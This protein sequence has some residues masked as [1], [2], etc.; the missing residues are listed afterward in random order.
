MMKFKLLIMFL[1][2]I[3]LVNANAFEQD[4][5]N[6]TLGHSLENM[7]YLENLSNQSVKFHQYCW[8]DPKSI[9]GCFLVSSI[10]L[11][12]YNEKNNNIAYLQKIEPQSEDSSLVYQL[13]IQNLK[14]NKIVLNRK[15][16]YNVDS[17][18]YADEEF[19]NINLFFKLKETDINNILKNYNLK[20]SNF[21]FRYL[22]YSENKFL[23][24]L[25]FSTVKVLSSFGYDKPQKV[26]SLNNL[27]IKKKDKLFF[28]QN[29]TYG[30]FC[31]ECTSPFF[32]LDPLT[33]IEI[34]STGQK[35]LIVGLLAYSF[36]SP[37]TLFFQMIG[38]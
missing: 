14:N 17:E 34:G 38:I 9:G 19:K 37:N 1:F 4:I 7:S 15:F 24:S 31:K 6:N 28:K 2:F 16:S 3:T 13:V 36:H 33:I 22:S 25:N 5:S 18:E 35:I 20:S 30:N 27:V 29:Y 12:D 26:E 21:S 23:F 32:L 10:L 11:V 8:D